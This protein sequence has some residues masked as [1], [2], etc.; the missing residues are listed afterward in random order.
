MTDRWRLVN[1][2]ELYDMDADPGQKNNVADKHPDVVGRLQ[3]AYEQYW[4]SVSQWDRQWQ[5]RPVLGSPH[6]QETYLCSEAWAPTKGGCPWSQGSV[7]GGMA[8]FGYWPVRVAD[9]GVYRIELRRWPREV[10][11]PM[12]E[13]PSGS[14]TVDAYLND[15]PIE[16]TLYPAVPRALPVKKVR[17]KVGKLVKEAEVAS[18]ETAKVFM[19]ELSAGPTEIETWLLDGDG[20]PLCGA[21]FVYVRRER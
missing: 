18:E 4:A 12:S 7:S 14:K 6:Q 13:V 9:A 17:L 8:S 15:K 19:V 2:G 11:A 3:A 10:D 16:G 5:G 1:R 21:Y 20:N